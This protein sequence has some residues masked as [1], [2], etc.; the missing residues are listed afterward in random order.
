[1]VTYDFYVG[2][3]HGSSVSQENWATLERDASAKLRQYKKNYTVT[4]PEKNSEAMAVCAMA[5]TLD[6]F[7][8]LENG[9]LAVQAVSVGSVSV[10]YDNSAKSV[11][12]STKSRE[13]ELYR[14]AST[15]LDIYRGA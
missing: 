4:A 2:E 15:Y 1:M 6:Y 12:I 9:N 8:Q 5:E 13:K 10:N 3:Y 11:D 7:E 14:A